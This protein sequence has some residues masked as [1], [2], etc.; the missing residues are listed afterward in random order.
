MPSVVVVSRPRAPE[1]PSSSSATRGAPSTPSKSQ[2][3]T[4]SP[5]KA[6]TNIFD[7]DATPRADASRP[8]GAISESVGN[9]LFGSSNVPSF[10]TSSVPLKPAVPGAARGRKKAATRQLVRGDTDPSINQGSA[11]HSSS[12]SAGGYSNST[13][14]TDEEAPISSSFFSNLKPGTSPKKTPSAARKLHTSPNKQRLANGDVYVDYMVP[15]P[16]PDDDARRHGL[17]SGDEGAYISSSAD[18]SE[19]QFRALTSKH[20]GRTLPE[21][22][23]SYSLASRAPPSVSRSSSVSHPPSLSG[24]TTSSPYTSRGPSPS[25]SFPRSQVPSESDD[26]DSDDAIYDHQHHVDPIQHLDKLASLARMALASAE[27]MR[28]QGVMRE[29]EPPLPRCFLTGVIVEPGKPLGNKV[30][31]SPSKRG[32]A[33][34]TETETDGEGVT[35]IRALPERR[36]GQI[37]DDL[38]SRS[39]SWLDTVLLGPSGPPKQELSRQTSSSSITTDVDNPFDNSRTSFRRTNSQPSINMNV[40]KRPDPTQGL[41]NIQSEPA[42]ETVL[43]AY[44]MTPSRSRTIHMTPSKS[45]LTATPSRMR[46][47]GTPSRRAR[48]KEVEEEDEARPTSQ[49]FNT[50]LAQQQV[51]VLGVLRNPIWAKTM[52]KGLEDAQ[53]ATGKPSEA[54]VEGEEDETEAVAKLRALLRR[55]VETGEGN[56]CLLVGPKGSGKTRVCMRRHLLRTRQLMHVSRPSHER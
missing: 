19:P 30:P 43:A 33:P 54:W 36:L 32:G 18:D 4:V 28:K 5:S 52:E 7:L 3:R 34:D 9:P 6:V 42:L 39:R 48:M 10:S 23:H 38:P 44:D 41:S 50:W 22:G 40:P 35:I 56:S 20:R 45:R 11:T 21:Q 17:S 51:R 37:N 24:Y 26:T 15:M 53:P 55:T 47:F 46:L 12:A 8:F 13:A 31:K 27:D 1:N 49:E 14:S 25:P 16:Q 29:G 2:R